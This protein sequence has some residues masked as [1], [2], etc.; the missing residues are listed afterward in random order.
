ME[1]YIVPC[2]NKYAHVCSHLFSFWF[3]HQLLVEVIYKQKKALCVIEIWLI[4]KFLDPLTVFFL[5]E[6]WTAVL[7]D[8]SQACFFYNYVLILLHYQQWPILQWHA[9]AL[10][11][12]S[13]FPRLRK[14]LGPLEEQ[15]CHI[16]CLYLLMATSYSGTLLVQL[17]PPW[18]ALL[19]C[20]TPLNWDNGS[21]CWPSEIRWDSFTC[22]SQW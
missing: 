5:R 2:N 16:L 9:L 7:F 11:Q 6:L 10:K 18:N 21:H 17:C 19:I 4:C 20:I 14:L 1:R 22:L 3:C 8:G 15:K 13:S 12:I